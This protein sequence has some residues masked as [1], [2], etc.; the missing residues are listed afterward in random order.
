MISKVQWSSVRFDDDQFATVMCTDSIGYVNIET[1][2]VIAPKYKDDDLT[3]SEGLM[4]VQHFSGKW[5]FI[6]TLGKVA[7]PFIYDFV[8]GFNNG[9][10]SVRLGLKDMQIN[11]LGKIVKTSK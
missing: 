11:K 10:A 4:G 5:G 6:D 1:G 2:F 9:E 3:F 7:I 8:H